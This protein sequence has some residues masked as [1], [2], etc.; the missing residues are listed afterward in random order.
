MIRF[1]ADRSSQDSSIQIYPNKR[2]KVNKNVAL[3]IP[4]KIITDESEMDPTC[5]HSKP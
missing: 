4:N 3:E 5:G 2:L 1:P